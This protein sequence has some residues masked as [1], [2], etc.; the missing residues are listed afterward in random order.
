MDAV[1]Y[2]NDDVQHFLEKHCVLMRL[3]IAKSK[4]LAQRYSI[5]WT[6]GLV[7]MDP[8]GQAHHTNVGYF[9]P[10]EFMAECSFGLGRV[11]AGT[12][13]WKAASEHFKRTSERWPDSFA[14]PA[15]LYWRGVAQKQATGDVDKLLTSWR[16]L[17]KAHPDSSWAA[18]VS[19]LRN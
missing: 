16:R 17:Q 9:A 13:D 18:K 10:Q 7:W 12:G 11:A 14:A 4:D 2:P 15:A 5:E 6:P 19:F 1:T 3:P 8:T